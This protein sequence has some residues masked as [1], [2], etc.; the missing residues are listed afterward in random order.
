MGSAVSSIVGGGVNIVGSAITGKIESE[1]I[2]AGGAI[3]QK[4]FIYNAAVDDANADFLKA[5]TGRETRR[6]REESKELLGTQAAQI[7]ASGITAESFGLLTAKGVE[8]LE[9]DIQDFQLEREVQGFSL[10]SSARL[11]RLQGVAAKVGADVESELTKV[12]AAFSILGSGTSAAG[13]AMG[14]K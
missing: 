13:G 12:G 5:A 2:E 4:A 1:A 3:K 7:G 9:Q 11:K 14:G 8:N 6:M 10:R